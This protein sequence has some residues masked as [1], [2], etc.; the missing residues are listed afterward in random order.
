MQFK[1]GSIVETGTVTIQLSFV[2]QREDDE[3]PPPYTRNIRFSVELAAP[4]ISYTSNSIRGVIGTPITSLVPINTGGPAASWSISSALPAG[5]TFDLSTGAIGGT[6]SVL[7]AQ[8]SFTV[9]ATNAGG[10]SMANISMSITA[11]VAPVISGGGGGG[12]G[13]KKT[14]LYLQIVDP[15]DVTKIY[16][17]PICVQV[18]S[19]TVSP[20]LLTS[21]CSG[22]D[23]RIN[24]LVEDGKF[25]IRVFEEGSTKSYREYAGESVNEKFEIDEV[26]FFPGTTR[27]ALTFPF[28]KTEPVVPTP[29]ST[30]TPTPTVKPLPELVPD[31][32]AATLKP[33]ATSV[34]QGSKPVTVTATPNLARTGLTIKSKDWEVTFSAFGANGEAKSLNSSGQIVVDQDSSLQVKGSGF[35]PNSEL[36][37]YFFS[38]P[39]LLGIGKTDGAGRFENLLTLLP[40]TTIG[41]HVLQL[42]AISIDK[43]PVSASIGILVSAKKPAPKPTKKPVTN[44][45]SNAVV[46]FDFAKFAIG[47]KQ[48]AA[49]K[50]LS[51]KGTLKINIIGYAQNTSGRD[52]LR[53]S[54]DRAIEVKKAI[55]KLAPKA[56]I[57]VLGAGVRRVTECKA[58]KNKCAL[59]RILRG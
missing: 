36:R 20:Q 29:T 22:S 58:Y 37:F 43:D 16:P 40:G 32:L 56:K 59:V 47:T 19:A 25:K 2:G 34:L 15:Q 1:S 21:G 6:P 51:L 14:A 12:G 3:N 52:D 5:L 7:L 54:L 9:T 46:P 33:G 44:L 26:K 10:S 17:K 8:G 42:S 57:T 55:L 45:V 38:S 49:I 41:D 35:L 39:G 4:V 24:L 11:P 18:Y 23:G 48:L 13:V 50:K 27:H 28:T 53:I 31:L 30:P